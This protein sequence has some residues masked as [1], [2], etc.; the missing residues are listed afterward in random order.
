MVA[1]TCATVSVAR[2]ADPPAHAPTLTKPPALTTFVE[3]PFPESERASGKG[4]TVVVQLAIDAAGRVTEVVVVQS[5]GP[6]FDEAA[7]RAVR[8]FAFSP[9]EFDG[10]PSPVQLTYKYE[11]I[12]KEETVHVPTVN[13]T[14]VV[15]DALT[16]HPLAGVTVTVDGLA[17]TTTD[18]TGTFSFIDVPEGKHAVRLSGDKLTTVETEE[19]IEHEKKLEVKYSVDERE[20][21]A[22]GEEAPDL[23][24][25]VTPPKVTKETVSVGIKTEEGRR[26]P[27][28]QG[29]TLR[30]VQSMPGV[31]RA[32]AGSGALVVWGAAPQDTRVYVD[33]VRVPMLYHL[34]GLRSTINSDLVRGIELTPG[35]YGA[36]YGRGLGGLVTVETRG[37]RGDRAHGYA[38]ADAMDASAMI[39]APLG[40]STRVAAAARK[41]YLDDTLSLFTSRDVNDLFP[42]ARY[43]DAQL[44]IEQDLRANESLTALALTSSDSLVRT[45]P[46]ADP[47]EVKTQNTTQ[48]FWRG[49]LHYRRQ[50]DD[51]SQVAVSP[52]IGMDKSSLVSAFGGTPTELTTNTTTFGVRGSWR[53]KLAEWLALGGGLD[54]EGASSSVVRTGAVTLPPREGDLYVFGEQPPDTINSDRWSTSL[55]SVAPWAQADFAFFGDRLHIVPG[56]RVDAYLT[57]GSALSPAR[58]DLPPIGFT[59]EDTTYEPRLSLRFQVTPKVLV[60]AAVGSYHQGPQPE[61]LSPVFGNPKL[62]L[63][64]AFHALA[65]ARVEPFDKT[66]AEATVFY[67]GSSNLVSRSASPTP[68][69]AQALVQDG[70]GRAYGAQVLVRRELSNG[71]FGWASYALIRSERRDHYGSKE[72]T[73]PSQ[74]SPWRLFDY[75]QTHVVTVVAS[76]E[77][78]HGWEVGARFRYTSGFPRTPVVGSYYDARRNLYEPYFG[79]QNSIRIPAFVALDVRAAKRFVLSDSTKLEVYV[80]VQ[81][82]TNRTNREDI[83]YDHDY[84]NRSYINGLPILPVVGAR[85][86]W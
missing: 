18:A 21:L 22:P 10:K 45:V 70:I 19:L 23:E 73:D 26:V 62:G 86:E 80:D 12:L 47:A 36:E 11:F 39:E 43:W 53:G 46:S 25:V 13:F 41:S 40:S 83:V 5:A 72:S 17:P 57:G 8:Q 52:S 77:L 61:D 67:S 35:G 27:G 50:L 2:A 42:I 15:R 58:P 69:E 63:S 20:E 38:A 29:D 78:G 9:A 81:N 74:S 28:T 66:I 51:G 68:V 1:T 44:R 4:A 60:K 7:V 82:A 30:V 14:G 24:I 16:K 84:Q 75:D 49:I 3:A 34:G 71:F 56:F 33:G 32:A 85:L 79:A 59:R 55:G 6:A 64:S 54:V 48:S 31:A 76:Y 37:L 65:G